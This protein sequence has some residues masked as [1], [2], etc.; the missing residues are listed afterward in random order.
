MF[1]SIDKEIGISTFLPTYETDKLLPIIG[2]KRLVTDQ[3]QMVF[4]H[5]FPRPKNKVFVDPFCGS[6]SVSRKARM[7]GFK[8]IA[9]ELLPFLYETNKLYLTQSEDD[10]QKM[11]HL[12][13]GVDAYIS[14]LNY[15]GHYASE[16]H[17]LPH[18]YISR[19][20]APKSD[21][22]YNP[23]Q[24]R[25][26]FTPRN[27]RFIDAVRHEIERSFEEGS[28]T[29]DEKRVLLVALLYE[30]T[31]K[32]NTS[33]NFSSFNR[34]LNTQRSRIHKLMTLSVPTLSEGSLTPSEMYLGDANEFVTHHPADIIY[35]DPPSQVQQISSAYHLL[36]TIT[37]WDGYTP[38]QK[39]NEKGALREKGGIR[40]DWR[41]YYSEYCSLQHADRALINLLNNCDAR[42]I[43]LSYP[44]N[45]IVSPDRLLE[46]LSLR[47]KHVQV[48]P[49]YRPNSGGIQTPRGNKRIENLY[50]TGKAENFSLTTDESLERITL[51]NRLDHLLG[52]TFTLQGDISPL[53]LI[54]SVVIDPQL[55]IQQ[56][57]SLPLSEFEQLITLLETNIVKD[58]DYSFSLLVDALDTPSLLLRERRFINRKIDHLVRH[59]TSNTLTS[60]IENL[61]SSSLKQRLTTLI[62][63]QQKH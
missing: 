6:G 33:G 58:D 62:Q 21:H 48:L 16:Q 55:P 36:H 2:S 39:L 52:F 51:F 40:S 3:L 34:T 30:V 19:Y 29:E 17:N 28:I 44:E 56:L 7:M 8:V 31:R 18:P 41:D 59:S 26:F 47:D 38:S 49:L 23:D 22:S 35:L 37:V 20:Y 25:L 54:G 15:E 1:I 11:F 60:L 61:S 46:L 50:I 43:V 13:G 12:H 14:M 45:G 57:L 53:T 32:A 4:S 42:H 10:L 5:L 63:H 27:A 24:E 9:N